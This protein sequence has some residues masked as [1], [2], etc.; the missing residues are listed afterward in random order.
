MSIFRIL[1]V[2]AFC[3][4]LLAPMNGHANSFFKSKNGNFKGSKEGYFFYKDPTEEE[5]VE[6]KKEKKPKKLPF[7]EG[8]FN[9]TIPWNRVKD[10]HPTELRVLL[11]DVKN[12][13]IQKPTE[14]RLLAYMTLQTMAMEKATAFQETWG[15]VL[16][17]N[18][19]LNENAKR[20][21]SGFVTNMLV[22][23]E[24][25]ELA[26]AVEH[27]KEEMGIVF[28]YTDNC[29]YC[30]KQ[31]EILQNFGERREWVNIVGV[32]I[33][34]E[35]EIGKE[36]KVQLVPDMWVVGNVDGEIKKRRLSAG[37]SSQKQIEKG[38]LNAYSRWFK[39]KNNYLPKAFKP[40][41]ELDEFIDNMP[42]SVDSE[43]DEAEIPLTDSE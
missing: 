2:S 17:Q 14:E 26:K 20:P 9:G 38:V 32:N 13:A 19:I 12:Y 16:Q 15:E 1:I 28:F 11:D 18:P 37:L 41:I 35:P 42:L 4:V 27:M 36:F 40:L 10:M 34:Q 7:S 33:T 21:A 24:R 31:K 22:V 5:K 23:E 30:D 8:S 39:G 3:A 29:P 6:E 43:Q 25:D